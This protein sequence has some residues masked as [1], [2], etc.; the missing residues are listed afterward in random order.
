MIN[1]NTQISKAHIVS[2]CL[3]LAFWLFGLARIS[4]N[5]LNRNR[6]RL[7]A[8]I[9]AILIVISIVGF[10]LKLWSM[11]MT[12]R[13]VFILVFGWTTITS[14]DLLIINKLN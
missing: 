11:P 6:I 4:Q 1:S 7:R 13:L 3:A 2:I 9:T 12:H 14:F 8:D 10:T 5:D